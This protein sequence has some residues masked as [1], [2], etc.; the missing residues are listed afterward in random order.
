METNRTLLNITEKLRAAGLRP[1]RQRQHLARLLFE[2]G[3]RHTS[4][5][6]L[7]REAQQAG[8]AVSLATVYNTLNRFTHA[9]LTREVTAEPGRV[10]FD[11][12]TSPH[13]HF[14][15]EDTGELID[16]PETALSVSKIPP[17]PQGGRVSRI[18]VVIRV[19]NGK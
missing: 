17:A 16:I 10:Y 19:A 11:T 7:H 1:T 3:D 13:H 9:G 8:L 2:N 5:E 14:L 18:D 4:A 12:N 6:Q 15:I